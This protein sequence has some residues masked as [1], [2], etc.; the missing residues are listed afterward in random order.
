G[1]GGVEMG[2]CELTDG[3]WLW[4]SGLA[5]YVAHHDVALPDEFM[6]HVL[7]GGTRSSHRDALA[8]PT[9]AWWCAWCARHSSGVLRGQLDDARARAAALRHE[10]HEKWLRLLEG[11]NGVSDRP[12][13]STGCERRAMHGWTLCGR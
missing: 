6:S 12:C 3:H 8:E 5:H 2:N 9:D 4:P 11:K 10:G 1:V 13:D 7:A